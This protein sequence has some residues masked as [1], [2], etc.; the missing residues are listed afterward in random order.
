ME[1]QK[2]FKEFLEYLN[3]NNVEYVIVGAYALAFY[4][5]P[6]YTGDIDILIN[7]SED[8]AKRLL[9][10]L[11]EFGFGSLDL[12]MNDFTTT[13]NVIQLGYAPVRIDILTSISGLTFEEVDKGK[14][15]GMYGDVPVYFIGKNEYIRNKRKIGRFKDLADLESLGIDFEN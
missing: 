3:K 10:A 13:D 11:R 14:E 4:G 15:E 1:V 2:D 12:K 6:R 5:V 9:K 7:P 8:N